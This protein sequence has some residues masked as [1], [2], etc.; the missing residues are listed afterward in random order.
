MSGDQQLSSALQVSSRAAT[1]IKS[2]R[3]AVRPGPDI[4]AGR[5]D[6]PALL[7]NA[8]ITD[9]TAVHDAGTW[10]AERPRRTSTDVAIV[11]FREPGGGLVALLK[12]AQSPRAA[13]SLTRQGENLRALFADPR[14]AD[15]THLLPRQLARGQIHGHT[16]V[17]EGGLDGYPGDRH[18]RRQHA[19]LITTATGF[20]EVLH[21]QTALA[22]TIGGQQLRRWLTG[23]VESLRELGAGRIGRI[24]EA[25]FQRLR[26]EVHLALE[27]RCIA[28]TWIHGDY[29][30]GNVLATRDG[31]LSGVVDWDQSAGGELPL[32]DLLHLLLYRRRIL[33]RRQLGAVVG[34][35]LNGRPWDRIE[36][37]TLLQAAA[38]DDFLLRFDRVAVL[39]YWLRYVATYAP[40]SDHGGNAHW[41]RRNVASVLRQL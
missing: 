12:V 20:L 22:E 6:L 19:E 9:P 7:E 24:Y 29:W 14:L 16:Y 2:I 18:P 30:L 26:D 35:T 41:V 28:T 10:I 23:P 27:G 11:T 36:R 34:D 39:L 5:R 40:M 15:I 31:R 37:T 4:V 38:D 3:L 32:H 8:E 13:Q 1:Y 21:R 17:L 33:E 25:P